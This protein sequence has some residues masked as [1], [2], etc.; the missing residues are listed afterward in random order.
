MDV[1]E[2][3]CMPYLF[4]CIRTYVSEC[5]CAFASRTQ[6]HSRLC[7]ENAG[8]KDVG[9]LARKERRRGRRGED[10]GREA[11][12]PYLILFSILLFFF[13]R[14][15]LLLKA[16]VLQLGERDVSE[17]HRCISSNYHR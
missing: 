8:A 14:L 5:A 13:L 3:A 16:K 6:G 9:E 11:K 12:G 1:T 4:L 17:W 2:Y 15:F 7:T 10:G